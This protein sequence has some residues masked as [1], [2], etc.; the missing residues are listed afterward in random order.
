MDIVSTPSRIRGQQSSSKAAPI[1]VNFVTFRLLK[2]GS[3]M[4]QVCASAAIINIEQGTARSTYLEP[5]Q[6]TVR[7]K[8]AF[9]NIAEDRL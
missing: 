5:R 8:F 4:L 2:G 7:L 6:L 1:R 9:R 3:A